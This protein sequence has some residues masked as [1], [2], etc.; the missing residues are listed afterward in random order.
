ME[1]ARHA[2]KPQRFTQRR[3]SGSAGAQQRWQLSSTGSPYHLCQQ[4]RQL[5]RT[6]WVLAYVMYAVSCAVLQL[7]AL[8]GICGAP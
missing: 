2:C 3:G 4:R 7:P 1:L 5:V 6:L 8:P